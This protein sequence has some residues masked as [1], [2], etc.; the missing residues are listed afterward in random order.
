MNIICLWKIAD[1]LT[2]LKDILRYS[3]ILKDVQNTIFH[4]LLFLI[5][6]WWKASFKLI[7]VKY[8]AFS[9]KLIKFWIYDI[10]VES[11]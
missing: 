1:A 10:D 9:I 6:I 5:K 7:C 4:S 8:F 2:N 11:F 3:K